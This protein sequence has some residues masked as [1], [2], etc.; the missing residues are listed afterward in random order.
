MARKRIALI[1]AVAVAM[2]PVA[3]A[4]AEQWP[5]AEL[6]NLLDD[7]LSVDRGKS[8][9]L[10]PEMHRRVTALADYAHGLGA[11][12]ILYTCSAFGAAIEAAARATGKPVL[13]PNEAMFEAAIA[14]GAKIG[15]I[16]TF[17]RSLP[18][19]EQE[20]RDL[21][22]ERG[23]RASITSI[24]VPAAM[25]ALQKGDRATHDAL[26]AEAAPQLAGCDAI[27]LA[28]FST[29]V[30]A[31]AVQLRVKVPVLTSPGS[32]VAKMKRLLLAA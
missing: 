27:M 24:C 8:P 22:A 2:P 21:V 9:E 6:V 26:L 17:E 12:G 18:G 13:K 10:S 16:G 11:D 20:F 19:M 32:A 1:H 31:P 5:D 3:A 30:A 14:A 28:Q 7:S 25:P 4:F 15:M 29:S 23:A